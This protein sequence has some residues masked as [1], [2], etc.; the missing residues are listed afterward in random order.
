[1]EKNSPGKHRKAPRS[2]YLI[3]PKTSFLQ[4][5]KKLTNAESKF[6]IKL[7]FDQQLS[8]N[9]PAPITGVAAPFQN[10]ISSAILVYQNSPERIGVIEGL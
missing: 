7:N 5:I 2:N 9:K 4:P 1:M 3:A 8:L 6:G 10:P